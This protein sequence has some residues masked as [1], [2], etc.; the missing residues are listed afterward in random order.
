MILQTLQTDCFSWWS[1]FCDH[2]HIAKIQYT[3]ILYSNV[4]YKKLLI[5]QKM[6]CPDEKISC[7][8]YLQNLKKK[9]PRIYDNVFIALFPPDLA[10]N[11]SV[12]AEQSTLCGSYV[13]NVISGT[14][15][16]N[17]KTSWKLMSFRCLRLSCFTNWKNRYIHN[18][19]IHV[20]MLH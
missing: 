16:V 15:S 17:N 2:F 4:C 18:T 10:Q 11:T 6:T 8:L 3:E 7:I 14:N 9:Q 19:L 13:F 20:P 12:T 1:N 5:L